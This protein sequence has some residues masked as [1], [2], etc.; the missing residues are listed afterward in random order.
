MCS[1]F[2][3]REMALVMLAMNTILMTTQLDRSIDERDHTSSAMHGSST[4]N[5]APK[6]SSKSYQVAQA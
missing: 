1:G 4:L 2:S 3:E 6:Q 5:V